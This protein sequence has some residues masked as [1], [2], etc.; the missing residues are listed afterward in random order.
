METEELNEELSVA[1][2]NTA[3]VRTSGKVMLCSACGFAKYLISGS[4]LAQI[5]TRF[6]ARPNGI[7]TSPRLF[8]VRIPRRS[9]V[10]GL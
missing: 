6:I 3:T 9:P 7:D 2:E 8:T 4:A 10:H 5:A 1:G